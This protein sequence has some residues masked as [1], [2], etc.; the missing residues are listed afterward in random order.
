MPRGMMHWHSCK[1][2]PSLLISRFSPER[3]HGSPIRTAYLGD[4]ARLKACVGFESE[5]TLEEE[6]L[7]ED[8]L[9]KDRKGEVEWAAR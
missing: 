2:C 9:A 3:F 5:S 1:R 7:A 8:T 6:A 4:T